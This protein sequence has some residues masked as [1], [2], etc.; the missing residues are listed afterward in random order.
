M[1]QMSS[2]ADQ[3]IGGLPIRV[4]ALGMQSESNKVEGLLLCELQRT[5]CLNK[6]YYRAKEVG[7]MG[8]PRLL[9][10]TASCGQLL[11]KF[12]ASKGH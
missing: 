2:S 1:T 10:R 3:N 6:L 4:S 8:I 9:A 5:E 12:R 7:M 11:C